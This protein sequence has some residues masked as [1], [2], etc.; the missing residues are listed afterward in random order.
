VTVDVAQAAAGRALAWWQTLLIFVA[1]PAALFGLVALIV[2]LT[3]RRDQRTSPRAEPGESPT[4]DSD[5]EAPRT[6]AHRQ[7]APLP[8]DSGA[9]ADDDQPRTDAHHDQ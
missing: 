8:R 5:P 9:A 3:T 6:R 2:V 1:T 4:A 7:D